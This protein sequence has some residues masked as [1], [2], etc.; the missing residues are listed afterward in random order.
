MILGFTWLVPLA[1]TLG[2][3]VWVYRGKREDGEG[4]YTIMLMRSV[5]AV[6]LSGSIW[7]IWWLA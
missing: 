6:L 4:E 3:G 2:L 7:L 5:G 1:I